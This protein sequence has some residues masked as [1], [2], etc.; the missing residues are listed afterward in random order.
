MYK[1]QLQLGCTPLQARITSPSC[2]GYDCPSKKGS[3]GKDTQTGCGGRGFNQQ[4]RKLDSK[5]KRSLNSVLSVRSFFRHITDGIETLLGGAGEDP[6][7]TVYG[8]TDNRDGG[9]MECPKNDFRRL[10]DNL[11]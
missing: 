2:Q 6:A 4:E 3:W 11:K 5:P 7:V 8:G 1:L 10:G 9:K